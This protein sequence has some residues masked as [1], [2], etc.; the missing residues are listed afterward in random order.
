MLTVWNWKQARRRAA[1]RAPPPPHPPSVSPPPPP[2]AAPRAPAPPPAASPPAAPPPAPPRRGSIASFR[3]RRIRPHVCPSPP[4]RLE[5]PQH[6]AL[7]LS[8][9]P[10]PPSALPRPAGE[11]AAAHEG[12][13]AGG[14]QRRLLA[15]LGR[16][17]RDE[18]HGAHPLLE[19]GAHVHRPQAAGDD[20]HASRPPPPPP[21]SSSSSSSHRFTSPQ[22]QPCLPK[23]HRH[24]PPAEL[25]GEMGKFGQVEISDISG[26]V[27][28]PDGKVI[29]TTEQVMMPPRFPSRL[30]SPLASPLVSPLRLSSRLSSRLSRLVSPLASPLVSP[31]LAPLTSPRNLGRAPAGAS[32]ALG[33]QPDQVPDPARRRPS[34]PRRLDRARAAR[35]GERHPHH[36]RRRR[37]HAHVAAAGAPATPPPRH[38][39]SEQPRP[40]PAVPLAPHPQPAS[41]PPC[42]PPSHQPPWPPEPH[43]SW[44]M[45]TTPPCACK[46]RLRARAN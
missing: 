36:R 24:A 39:A 32:P 2:A 13:C 37:L 12:L 3:P 6:S 31:L 15:A 18:R 38:R 41:Q 46:L 23:T 4:P 40:R 26:Y 17:A 22:P 30:V 33:G 25:Q 11:G 28:L 42:P 20:A 27:E 19:D 21:S 8:P 16:R 34:V 29:S 35:R 43:A 5:C 9:P 1:R 14:R 44:R 7:M 10:P 45:Q